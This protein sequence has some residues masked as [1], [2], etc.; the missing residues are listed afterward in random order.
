MNQNL[1]LKCSRLSFVIFTMLLVA[2]ASYSQ[3]KKARVLFV[4]NSY[5]YFNNM[6]QIVADM[7]ATTG[8][9]L[10]YDMSAP[11]GV[12]FWNHVDR[13]SESY[14]PTMGKV[15]AGG[16]DYVILQEQS[17]TPSSPPES[18]YPWSFVYAKFLVDSIRKYSPCAA[19]IFY[20]TWGRKHGLPNS[21]NSYYPPWPYQCTYMS[22]DSITRVRYMELAEYLDGSVSPVGPVWRHIRGNYTDIELYEADESH[23]S[24]AGSYAAAC[25][26]FTAIFKKPADIVT[27]DFSLSAQVAAN[28][29][30][31]AKKIVYDSLSYWSI[32]RHQTV[33]AFT[34]EAGATLTL[35][36]TNTSTNATQYEW[37]FGDGRTST[38]SDPVHTYAAT[39]IYTVRLIAKNAR[40]SDTTVA[41][42]YITNEPSAA[43]FSIAPNP[44][45]NVFKVSSSLF[46]QD[47]YRLKIVNI[48]GQ[49]VHEQRLS[50][51]T[52]Q[53]I[54][55]YGLTA[56]IYTVSIYTT[57]RV[58]HKKII[59]Q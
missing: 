23:P 16:W 26:M 11:G 49:L 33:A 46:A 27:Y 59:I 7:A 37:N 15:R 45:T 1:L 34:V 17:V 3:H 48:M 35:N 56:G 24:P 52:V 19:I 22:M 55:V 39:G 18:Y 13:S 54:P 44:A 42:L 38:A 53:T 2:T 51:A 50:G 9:T 5:T 14:I 4:G 58:Y 21:C 32:G 31:A 40:C 30:T 29:R 10:D 36:F 47:N 43:S 57:R 6:P 25:S 8:D 20:M 12:T 41:G 28:I